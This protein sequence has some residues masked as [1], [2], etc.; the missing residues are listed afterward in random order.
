[1]NTI[2]IKLVNGEELIAVTSQFVSPIEACD[3]T[4]SKVRGI[5]VQPVGNNQM[6]IGFVPWMAGNTDGEILIRAKDI[7]TVYDPEPN[8]ERGYLE[9]TSGIDLSAGTSR[10]GIKI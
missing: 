1:M 7:I 10:P 8:I 4:I 9:Q 3:Y 2:C 5:M 6:A